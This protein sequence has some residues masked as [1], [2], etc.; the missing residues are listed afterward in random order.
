MDLIHRRQPTLFICKLITRVALKQ[1][2]IQF[3]ALA[4]LMDGNIS[5]HS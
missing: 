4:D 1:G 5:P 3:G 2:I